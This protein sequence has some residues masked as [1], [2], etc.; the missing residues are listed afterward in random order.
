MTPCSQRP[1]PPRDQ[2]DALG[3]KPSVREALNGRWLQRLDLR[4]A[5]GGRGAGARLEGGAVVGVEV[6]QRG[7]DIRLER[8]SQ[9]LRLRRRGPRREPIRRGGRRHLE[10]RDARRGVRG[11]G[12][13]RAARGAGGGSEER[14]GRQLRLEARLGLP[15]RRAAP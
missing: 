1:P 15:P 12:R 10:R 11:A 4:R 7:G 14:G 6:E 3:E 2:T 9:R 13:E 8:A 5:A